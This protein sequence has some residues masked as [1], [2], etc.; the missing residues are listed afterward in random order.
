MDAHVLIFQRIAWIYRYFFGMQLRAYREALDR[1]S[2]VLAAAP[3]DPILDIGCGT[4]AFVTAL[5]ERGYDAAGVDAAP[6]MVYQATS[7]GAPCAEGNAVD[8]LAYE[9]DSFDVVTMA[10][11]AHGLAQARRLRLYRE[12]N[13]IARKQV[14]IHDYLAD[15]GL[16]THILETLEGGT[17]YQFIQDPRGEM[18]AVFADVSITDVG[19]NAAWYACTPHN[20]A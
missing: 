15:G 8:G 20:E 9:D 13:R 17:Y 14:L 7:A 3:G 19:G 1:Y 16:V 18:L 11:V 10:Y 5:R 6:N 12:A 2:Q 4:G